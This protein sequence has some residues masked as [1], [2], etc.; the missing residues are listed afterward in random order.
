[1]SSVAA[2]RAPVAAAVPASAAAAPEPGSDDSVP[3]RPND[4]TGV[5]DGPDLVLPSG[6]RISLRKLGAARVTTAQLDAIL[7]GIKLLPAADQ[8]VVARS[9][10]RIDLLP[11]AA[12]EQGINGRAELG[13]TDIDPDANGVWKPTAVRIAAARTDAGAE[14]STEAVQHEI[15]HVLAVLRNGDRSERTAIDY[16][17]RY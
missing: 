4:V 9:G 10:V 7:A 11:V 15:G 17:S 3:S 2:T 6:I 13:A 5:A 14:S 1:M 16:A 8:Q 12:L